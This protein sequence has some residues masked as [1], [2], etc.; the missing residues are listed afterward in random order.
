[1]RHFSSGIATPLDLPSRLDL[2]IVGLTR[3]RLATPS[4]VGL[5]RAVEDVAQGCNDL[6]TLYD[7]IFTAPQ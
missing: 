6:N 7:F 5:G 3:Y 4:V 1:M 2:L